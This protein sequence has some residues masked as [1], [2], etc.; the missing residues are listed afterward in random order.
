MRI[1]RKKRPEKPLIQH[2]NTNE[3]ITSPEVRLLD[4]EN[5]NLG[6]MKTVEALAR[7]LEL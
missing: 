6:V 3:Q 2:Y 1:S 5:N 4:T 7:A